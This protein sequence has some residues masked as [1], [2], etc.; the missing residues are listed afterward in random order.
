M[1]TLV[2]VESPTKA[3][4]ITKF[5]GK[6]YR[7]L[8]SFGHVRDLPKS[9]IGV[10]IE[11]GFEPTYV[12]S[13]DKIKVVKELKDAAAKAGEILFAS[14]QDREGEA[15]SYHLAYLLGIKP[16]NAKRITFHEITKTALTEALEHPRA[17][18]LKLVDAQQARR[19]LDRLV[20]YEMSPFLWRKVARGLSAGRVQ[21]VAVRLVVEREREIKAFNKEEYWTIEG[22]FSTLKNKTEIFP[23]KLAAIKGKRLDKMDLKNAA[24]V[25]AIVKDLAGVKYK[26]AE[27]EEKKTS[28][29]PP[30]PYT[31]SSLQ[32]DAN[33]SLGF[34]AKQTMMLAQQLYEGVELGSGGQVGLITY[35]RTDAVN[36]SQKFLDDAKATIT[37]SFGKNY[38]LEAPRF[39]KNKNKSA[40][41]AHEAVRPTEA[42]RA[43]EEVKPFLNKNQHRLYHLIWNRALATQMAAAELNATSVDIKSSNDYTFRATGQ[44]ITFDGWLKLYPEKAKENALPKLENGEAAV[45]SELKP[46]QHFTEPPARYSDATLVKTL[47]EYG[48]GRPSTYAPTIATIEARLYVERDDKKRFFPSDIAYIVN[49]LLVEHFPH[50]VDYKFTAE[51]ENQLDEI[52]EGLKKWQPV[53][54]DFYKPFKENLIKKD[55]ELNK[56]ELTEEKTDEKCEKCEKPMVIKVGRF[57]KFLACSGYPDCKH[58][59][60]F[61]KEAE[62][63]SAAELTDELCEKCG[64]PMQR[65]VGRF[66]P[67]L[68]CSGYP[69]CKNIKRIENKLNIK[70]PDCGEGDLVTRKSKRGKLFY[71]CNA[72]PKC[73]FA[74]WDKPTGDK[75]PNCGKLLVYGAKQTVKCSDK[76]CG[77]I[78]D[79]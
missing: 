67:F 73:T 23:A 57:G 50:I 7:V 15:I 2:I 55:K 30:P 38:A 32:Q 51:L 33:N 62:E 52:A 74:L 53:I 18:D 4:T 54:A 69:D 79:K 77:Y 19:V 68:G 49:D 10:D 34:S 45:C 14:D 61:G 48:I 71:G 21:S 9:K 46:E 26:I 17:L 39:Y 65:R 22:Q 63:R 58:T 28:R 40:Q 8:S 6:D 11:H 64:K 44:V 37:T 35:M 47:E 20:G 59:K 3:K 43:P 66:G 42:S 76:E 70:C 60:P 75:C 36:L 5:L 72:Y 25:D 31:T 12:V 1:K 56:K 29:T 13:K 27:L 78:A 41:E 24:E 16:E